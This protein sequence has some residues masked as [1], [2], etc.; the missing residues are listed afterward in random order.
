MGR[1]A[2]V[3]MGGTI[4]M[5]AGADGANVP[6]LG[7]EELLA[8]VPGRERLPAL[9]AVDWGLVPASHLTFDQVLDVGRTLRDRLLDPGV[10]G[11]V[12]VQ[13]TDTLDETA[14]AWDLLPFPAKP[15]VVVGAMRS[16]SEGGYEGPGNLRD[17]IA[18][19]ADPRLAS[20]GVVVAMGGELHGADQVLKTDT[21]AYGTFKSPNTGPLG[22]VREGEVV[23]LRRRASRLTLPAIPEAAARPVPI[24]SAV[25]DLDPAF[26]ERAV[27]GA[28]AAVFELTGAGNS[29]PVLLDVAGRLMAAGVPVAVASRVLTGHVTAGYGFPG[30]SSRWAASGAILAGYLGARK[31]R[32]ALALGVGA[33]LEGDALRRLVG[34][35]GGGPAR[36]T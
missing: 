35:H 10:D 1:I 24:V 22:F 15:V 29:Q 23:L 25:L 14:F 17:A 36:T 9:E 32:L 4:S 21:H 12:V 7:G 13:G 31:A 5:R 3:F 26:V 20:E 28:R 8:S 2:V 16:A 33:G 6:V 30:G 18:T 34:Q 19:A 27:E 11:A